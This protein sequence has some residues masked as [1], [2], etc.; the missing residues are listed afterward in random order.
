[1]A[2]AAAIA[3][4]QAVQYA[5]HFVELQRAI[6]SG[7]IGQAQDALLNFQRESTVAAQNGVDPINQIFSLRREFSSIQSALIK[8]DIRVAQSSLSN[9]R[10]ELGVPQP[11]TQIAPSSAK[12]GSGEGQP[13]LPVVS[14]TTGLIGT[15]GGG[16]S[17][18]APEVGQPRV[19]RRTDSSGALWMQPS[20]SEVQTTRIT[21]STFIKSQPSI[22]SFNQSP[23]VFPTS[24]A[25]LSK[26]S[27]PVVSTSKQAVLQGLA[28][29][30]P[31]AQAPDLD[32]TAYAPT[33]ELMIGSKGMS[34]P[35]GAMLRH[36]NNSILLQMMAFR[37]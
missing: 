18:G 7:D 2:T 37:S 3:Q 33:P 29:T 4:S 27:I 26:P 10:K 13:D 15:R 30:L 8:G 25:G 21:S 22:V 36:A 14:T 31:D 9:L 5:N 19:D 20:D 28:A 23:Q 35:P 6:D 11:P 17:G 24:N 1:M 16:K 12:L 34:I 32:G